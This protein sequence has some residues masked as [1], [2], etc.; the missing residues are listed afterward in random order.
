MARDRAPLRAEFESMLAGL[1]LDDPMT[2]EARAMVKR[3]IAVL[4]AAPAD[5]PDKDLQRFLDGEIWCDGE[6]LAN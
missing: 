2:R 4:D 3:C 1:V 6:P 5:L